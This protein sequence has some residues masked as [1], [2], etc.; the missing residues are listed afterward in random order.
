MP[1]KGIWLPGKVAGKWSYGAACGSIGLGA[2]IIA[3]SMSGD[4]KNLVGNS[5]FY[6]PGAIFGILI[7]ISAIMSAI[8]S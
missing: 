3:A 1:F 7:A 6:L 5:K 2:C 8:M 4:S